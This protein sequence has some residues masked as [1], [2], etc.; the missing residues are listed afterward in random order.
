[1]IKQLLTT[2]LLLSMATT[3]LASSKKLEDIAQKLGRAQQAALDQ[4]YIAIKPF[5][6]DA[7]NNP[8]FSFVMGAF[9]NYSDLLAAMTTLKEPAQKKAVVT[10][11][12]TIKTLNDREKGLITYFNNNFR[13]SNGAQSKG[14]LK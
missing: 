1:M 7:N 5:F 4:Q 3:S 11:L 8:N 10:L 12:V 9:T 13:K 2:G 6:K 14:A